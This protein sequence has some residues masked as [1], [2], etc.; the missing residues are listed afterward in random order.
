MNN[1][2]GK[3]K[4]SDADPEFVQYDRRWGKSK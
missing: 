3:Y 4:L 1:R 2:I